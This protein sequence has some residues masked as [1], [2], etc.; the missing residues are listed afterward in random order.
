M[1]KIIKLFIGAIIAAVG[2]AVILFD[3]AA[4]NTNSRNASAV[5]VRSTLGRGIPIPETSKGILLTTGS[6]AVS[7]PGLRFAVISDVHVRSTDEN[8]Q[9][10]MQNALEDL[11][12]PQKEP[13]DLI[14]VNG[15]LGDGLPED[16]GALNRIIRNVRSGPTQKTPLV[17]TIGNHEFY[18]AYHLLSTSAWNKG[19]FPNGETDEQAVQRF[20]NFAGRDKVYTDRVIKGY[21]FIFLGSEKSSMSDRK[22]GDGVY[23]SEGQLSWLKDKLAENED[24]KKPIF[25]FLHQPVYTSNS[26]SPIRTQYVMQH[27]ELT[28]IMD[29]YPQ[30]ILFSGHLH[31]K[32]GAPGTVVHEIFTMFEDSSVSRVRQA[33]AD[34]SEGLVVEAEG[35][36]VT[37]QGR[38]FQLHKFIPDYKYTLN[39]GK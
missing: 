1:N 34:A 22:I 13:L 30:I 36:K 24:P 6:K 25:L 37:V 32:L 26:D 21:H 15:D 27:E 33:S 23:L 17:F 18:K 31:L 39:Y 20:L 29:A 16:Y 38:D 28:K 5:E 11:L 10:K 2:I 3:F 8:V 9:R 12:D 14:V 4:L 19:T 35:S 7:N